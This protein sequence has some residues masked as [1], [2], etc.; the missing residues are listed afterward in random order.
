MFPKHY[1]TDS[2]KVF[3]NKYE[4]L[5]MNCCANSNSVNYRQKHEAGVG[6]NV[7]INLFLHPVKVVSL[8]T[9]A[10]AARVI[11]NIVTDCVSYLKTNRFSYQ[12]LKRVASRESNQ[13]TAAEAG[14][15]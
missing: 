3:V 5:H 14:S 6:R 13:E 12:I 15:A 7:S 9:I 1:G 10:S 2:C 11:C 4:S 8:R